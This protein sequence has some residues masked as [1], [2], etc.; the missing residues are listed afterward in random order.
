MYIALHLNISF[1]IPR[2]FTCKSYYLETRCA[3]L[4]DSRGDG[5]ALLIRLNPRGS[6]RSI[7]GE[8]NILFSLSP[9]RLL[10]TLDF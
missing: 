5:P 9:I 7:D 1:R 3:F 8:M 6:A 2:A 4:K 10:A